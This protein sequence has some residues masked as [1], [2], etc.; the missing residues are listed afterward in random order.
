EAVR[1]QI[2]TGIES[3]RRH[4]GRDP[5]GI[6]LPECAYRP[7]YDWAP[8]V[9]GPRVPKP[10]PR[11][12]IEEFLAAEGIEYFFV[13]THLLRGGQAMGTYAQLHPALRR[14]AERYARE[15]GGRFKAEDFTRSPN[16]A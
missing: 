1:A 12:G 11:R 15:S 2:R 5:R 8:P 13:D 10:G 4:F 14:L 3:Y 16:A 6:W 7:A 9:V